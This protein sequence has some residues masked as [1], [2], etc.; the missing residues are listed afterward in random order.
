MSGYVLDRHLPR[1]AVHLGFRGRGWY[2]RQTLPRATPLGRGVLRAPR[3]D[4][5]YGADTA[6]LYA[7][8][9]AVMPLV[10]A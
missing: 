4:P 2:S 7:G 5:R 10:C 9:Y 1:L 3:F 8:K 6:R